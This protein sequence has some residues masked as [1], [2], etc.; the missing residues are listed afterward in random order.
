[1]NTP[2][3]IF[4]DGDGTLWYPTSTKRTEK[5][6]WIYK[7]P[8]LKDSYLEHLSLTPGC[9][10]TVRA[11]HDHG[12]KLYLISANPAP[13]EV[14]EPELREKLERFGLMPYFAGYF[15]SPGDNPDGKAEIMLRGLQ[16]Y[17][18]QPEHGLMVGD[19]LGYDYLPAINH[20]IQAFWIDN[21]V[22][23]RPED[24]PE[25]IATI[26]ELPELIQLLKLP[27]T[28]HTALQEYSNVW[29]EQ[30]QKEAEILKDLFGD[31]ITDIEHIGSTSIP[32]L[33][34]KPIIDIGV[35]IPTY[36]EHT[37]FTSRL[38]ELGYRKDV[39]STERH[40]Y[41]KG[42]PTTHHLSIAFADRGGFWPRQILF[43][44]YLRDHPAA[45]DE[46]ARIK[47]A[48]LSEDPT[49]KLEY[50]AGKTDFV[51]RILELAGWN[52]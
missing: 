14:A 8:E 9:L 33:M 38:A 30:Y 41:R 47:Q 52:Q 50:V 23:S 45:R 34:A 35:M 46:Y 44:D 11:L 29:P 13:P 1:M 36:R 19:S 15:S 26:F 2:Q 31:E 39:S 4:L 22:A 16:E 43:R 40:F 27:D 32:G 48:S 20:G 12:I 49:G 7:D 18:L 5:P 6:H 25:E 37:D 28:A 21:P 3:I 51:Y 42:F 24:L 17:N 10:E